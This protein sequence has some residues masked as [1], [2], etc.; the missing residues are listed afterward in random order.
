MTARRCWPA[1]ASPASGAG[2]SATSSGR[3]LL[4]ATD[5]LSAPDDRTIRFRLAR[6]FPQLPLALGKAGAN[7]CVMMPERL[8]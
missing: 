4:A 8:A 6:P 7:V 1:T 3:L 2:A 5:E